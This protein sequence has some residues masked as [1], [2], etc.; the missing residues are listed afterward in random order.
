MSTSTRILEARAR[1]GLSQSQLAVRAGIPQP[2]LSA[3]E[4]GRVRPRP[5]NL[6]RILAATA[7]QLG[8]A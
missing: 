5:E 1:A 3:D 8:I 7:E 6:A 4:A 2:N